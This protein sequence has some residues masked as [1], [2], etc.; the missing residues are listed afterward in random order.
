MQFYFLCIHALNLFLEL[1]CLK[2]PNDFYNC[3]IGA[4]SQYVSVF[5]IVKKFQRGAG[6]LLKE[7]RTFNVPV[8]ISP[9]N[10]SRYF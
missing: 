2:L 6:P 7:I 3:N 8:M 10:P 1:R 9:C 5:L 4:T